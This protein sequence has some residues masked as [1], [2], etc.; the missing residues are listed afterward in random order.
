MIEPDRGDDVEAVMARFLRARRSLMDDEAA[1]RF[2]ERFVAGNA[3]LTPVE[4]LEIYRRQFWLRHTESLVEDFPGVGY[5]LGQVQWE[6]L[7]EEYLD[8]YPPS[9]PSLRDLGRQLASFAA[10]RSWLPCAELAADMAELEWAL[11][12]AFDASAHAPLDPRQLAAIPDHAWATARFAPH[13]TLR[14][15]SSR[16]PVLDLLRDAVAATKRGEPALEGLAQVQPKPTF[17]AVYRKDLVVHRDQLEPSDYALLSRLYRGDELEKACEAAAGEIGVELEAF[18]ERLGGL[19][20]HWSARGY[21]VK[22][23]TP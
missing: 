21:F 6:R 3:R 14:L 10:S 22:V 11:I 5:I 9:T 17:V 20:Q 13:P 1:R 15:L 2:A 16:Y 7:V 8:E 12:E 18:A 4:Q 23:L 19:F